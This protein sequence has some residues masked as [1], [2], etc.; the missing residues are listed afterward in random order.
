MMQINLMEMAVTLLAKNKY[1]ATQKFKLERPVMMG[2]QIMEIAVTQ[3][4]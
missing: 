3:L 4:A 2:I 1:V